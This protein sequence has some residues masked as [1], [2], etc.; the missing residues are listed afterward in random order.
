MPFIYKLKKIFFYISP[1]L[2]A[3]LIIFLLRKIRGLETRIIVKENH[4]NYEPKSINID[5]YSRNDIFDISSKR[6]YHYGGQQFISNEQPFTKFYKEGFNSLKLYYERNVPISS[7]EAHKIDLN[8]EAIKPSALKKND[9][10]LPWLNS[11]NNSLNGE[12]GLSIKHGHSAFGP[13]SSRKLKLEAERLNL[14]YSSIKNKGYVLKQYFPKMYSDVPKGY[15]L[16]S[17]DN[18][19]SFHVVSGKHRVA[20]LI[21]LGWKS[22]PVR[23]EPSM[24]RAIFEKDIDKWP[25][26]KNL[27]YNKDTAL[28]VFKTYFNK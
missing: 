5:E 15:F 26:V 13:I 4:R 19:W 20:A 3:D 12:Y 17:N 21:H 10:T 9:F 7:F 22:I 14:C 2:L 28:L 16:I 25:M 6:L 23:F 1:P 11:A 8:E 27:T 24:P 18:S